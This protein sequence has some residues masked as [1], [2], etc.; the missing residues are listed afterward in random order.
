MLTLE[1]TESAVVNQPIVHEV[2]SALR[3]DGVQLAVDDFGSG[4]SSLAF[5]AGVQVDE[6]KVDSTF[7]SAMTESPQAAAIVRTTVDLGNRLGVRVVAEGV[8][9]FAQRAALSELGCL[10]AQ[11]WYFSHPVPS[12]RAFE[13][14]VS[15]AA[16]AN[17]KHRVNG[18]RAVNG[19]QAANG[20]H[21][22]LPNNG[23]QPA[24]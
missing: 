24:G 20:D 21:P 11:G 22:D 14:M 18:D 6:V 3:A 4:V 1:I 17:G 19:A 23:D 16:S 7:V 12:E 2:L 10:A 9:T 5:L 15:M 8:E 13:V